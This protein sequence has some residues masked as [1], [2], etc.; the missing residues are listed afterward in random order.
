[1]KVLF[2][3]ECPESPA[4][5]PRLRYFCS[6]FLERG[7]S[8]D[9]VVENGDGVKYF[10]EGVNVCPIDYLKDGNKSLR[11]VDWMTKFIMTLLVDYKGRFFYRKSKFFWLNNDYDIVFC[12]SCY[13]FPLTVAAK[14]AKAKGVP[15]FVDLRDIAEQSPD[16]FYIFSRKPPKF[17][18]NALA[19]LYR[20]VSLNRRNRV[21][22]QAAAV[23]TVSPWHVETLRKYNN[24]VALVYNGFDEKS[25][26]PDDRLTIRFVVTYLGRVY[27]EDMR[28]PRPLF[29]AVRSMKQKYL[30]DEQNIV[31]RWFTDSVSADLI[32]G[33][34][35]EYGISELVEC[36]D[37]V[38]PSQL[39]YELSNSSVI[40]VLAQASN[41]KKRYFGIMTTKFFE[42]VGVNRPVLLM[43]DN[44]DTLA[45]MVRQTGCGLV[46]SDAKEIEGFLTTKL[47]EW[48]T[49]GYTKSSLDEKTRMEFS[50]KK[51]AEK[52]EKMI[53]ELTG[54]GE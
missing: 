50:R 53:L 52:V 38:P 32:K 23:F 40:L 33:L 30:V 3:G 31:L 16:D 1:M 22:Q 20:K 15:L 4:Y 5:L 18:G 44:A 8:I 17:F 39:Q 12:S 28:N 41:P 54:K 48:R 29:E 6:Y 46:S 36:R 13:T 25:F 49:F 37:F 14:A 35:K 19:R 26:Y 24:N 27:N 7:W 34:A 10:P 9:Y 21:L 42:A 11:T 43:P 51:G 45:D 2:F 47:D